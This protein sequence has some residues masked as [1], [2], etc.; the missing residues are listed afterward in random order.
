MINKCTNCN[1]T[2]LHVHSI[3]SEAEKVCDVCGGTGQIGVKTSESN[4]PLPV[5]KV[6]AKKK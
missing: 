4:E 6:V 5:K 1:G 3:P 2:G